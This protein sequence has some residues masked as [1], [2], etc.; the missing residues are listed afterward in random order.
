MFFTSKKRK[1]KSLFSKNEINL[2]AL[3]ILLIINFFIFSSNQDN[4][5]LNSIKKSLQLAPESISK[6][7]DFSKSLIDDT[8]KYFISK[9]NLINQY[10][11]LKE[12]HAKLKVD[13]MKLADVE[14]ENIELNNK[15]NIKKKY[16]NESIVCQILSLNYNSQSHHFLV[17]KGQIDGAQI[18]QIVVD[19]SGIVGQVVEANETSS[20]VRTILSDQLY[21]TGYIK[22]GKSNYQS[23]IKGDNNFLSIDYF[24]KTNNINLNDEVFTT[25]DN[26]NIPKG[27]RIGKVKKLINTELNDFYKVVVE[28]SSNPYKERFLIIVK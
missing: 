9:K 11:N 10:D 19:Q 23:L 7:F 4:I 22:S 18:G 2:N 5:F 17:D 16:F 14:S 20:V 1:N 15:L 24:S 25:G 3:L 13:L 26:L 28:P 21:L 27:L 6:I 12:E 8:S